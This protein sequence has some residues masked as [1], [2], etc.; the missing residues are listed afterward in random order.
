MSKKCNKPKSPCKFCFKEVSLKTGLQCQGACRKWAHFSC[1]NYTPGKIHDIKAGFIKVN[2]PCPDCDTKGLKEQVLHEPF[3]CT[4]EVCPANSVPVCTFP[5]CPSK[6]GNGPRCP[7]CPKPCP[8]PPPPPCAS[9][10][11]C[12]PKPSPCPPTPCQKPPC[13]KLPSCQKPPC[14]RPPPCPK[15][16]SCQKPPCQRPP[17]CKPP[18]CK[19]SPCGKK[20]K[21]R[22]CNSR[23]SSCSSDPCL[24]PP[25]TMPPLCPPPSCNPP[26]CQPPPCLP[27]PCNPPPCQSA[28]PPKGKCP[29][30][31]GKKKSLCSFSS[32][33][34]SICV[35][36]KKTQA[37]RKKCPTGNDAVVRFVNIER[38][39]VA[40]ATRR[41]T[42]A[43]PTRYKQQGYYETRIALQHRDLSIHTR[44]RFGRHRGETEGRSHLATASRLYLCERATA[45]LQ[46]VAVSE[47]SKKFFIDNYNY[48]TRFIRHLFEEYR[49][50][51]MHNRRAADVP[52]QRANVQ[53]AGHIKE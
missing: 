37:C 11:P 13:Q 12:S 31:C 46:K 14:Q 26:S 28:R 49:R 34:S 40:F 17:P 35:S 27:T 4:N 25:C 50:R 10:P 41:A 33:C 47:G 6:S 3:T 32:S 36:N 43:M 15:P 5:T 44:D 48:L 21:R 2:C 51:S 19:P 53:D 30:K 1:L 42:E 23:S 16:P 22:K 24:P 8:P 29:N 38:T 52:S 9:P 18:P 7:Q 45:S 20:K 39:L